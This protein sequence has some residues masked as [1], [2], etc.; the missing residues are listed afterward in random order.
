M[1]HL[2]LVPFLGGDDVGFGVLKIVGRHNA[3][4]LCRKWATHGLPVFFHEVL[5][6]NRTCLAD[7]DVDMASTIDDATGTFFESSFL[8]FVPSLSW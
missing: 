4:S 5:E 6:A 3:S 7:G 8:L 2:D 1:R